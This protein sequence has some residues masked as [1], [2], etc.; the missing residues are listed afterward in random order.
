MFGQNLDDRKLLEEAARVSPV[1]LMKVGC[2]GC[3]VGDH[4]ANH[5]VEGFCV[6][7]LDTT[8]AGDCFSAAFIYAILRG[9][10]SVQAAKLANRLAASIV[11]VLGCDFTNLDRD[12]ILQEGI[13]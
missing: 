8:A 5:H 13:S 10:S 3:Y 7:P 4:G 12:V 1:V 6:D 2:D 9:H 11:T